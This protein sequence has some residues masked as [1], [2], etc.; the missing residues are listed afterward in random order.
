MTEAGDVHAALGAQTQHILKRNNTQVR[1]GA[2]GGANHRPLNCIFGISQITGNE[3][4]FVLGDRL[5]PPD[6]GVVVVRAGVDDG[7]LFVAVRQIDVRAGISEAKLQHAHARH[8]VAF[9]ECVHLG[10]DDSKVF[11]DE[12]QIAEA[13][14]QHVEKIVLGSVY[15]LAVNGRWLLRRNLPVL[16]ESAEVIETNDVAGVKRPA[17][18]TFPPVV[19]LLTKRIPTIERVSPTLPS[20]RK[21]VRRNSGDEFRLEV[22]TQLE[23]VRIGPDI[24]AVVTDKDGD[25]ADDADSRLAAARMQSAPLL[26]E[27]ILKI[28]ADS[29]FIFQFNTN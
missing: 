20:R 1:N 25:I 17:H 14:A 2:F 13:L 28:A 6:G 11:G 22:W 27:R 18:A 9:A 5:P 24:G 8:L 29:E 3:A 4:A 10:G 15:P 21:R 7:V 12:R 16:F 26:E 23:D 19:A